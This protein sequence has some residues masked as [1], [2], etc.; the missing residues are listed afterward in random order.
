MNTRLHLQ[1]PYANAAPAEDHRRRR[2]N[3]QT[4]DQCRH[5]SHGTFLPETSQAGEPTPD[6]GPT[7]DDLT[8]ATPATEAHA[9]LC[10]PAGTAHTA[11]D[12]P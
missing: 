10:L 5:G 11:G 6:D 1:P 9:G 2:W 7:A 4:W 8:A 12:R 3:P